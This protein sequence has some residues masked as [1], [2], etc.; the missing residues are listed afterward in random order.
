VSNVFIMP[1]SPRGVAKMSSAIAASHHSL[2]PQPPEFGAA[3]R[4]YRFLLRLRQHAVRG[5]VV[6]HH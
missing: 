6:A 5:R 3:R 1:I 2:K 4:L